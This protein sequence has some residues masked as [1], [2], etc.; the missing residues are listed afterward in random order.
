MNIILRQNIFTCHNIIAF[1]SILI[2]RR[3]KSTSKKKMTT[4]AKLGSL[5]KT[6]TTGKKRSA[7]LQNITGTISN[8]QKRSWG[9]SSNI[10]NLAAVNH[11]NDTDSIVDQDDDAVLAGVPNHSFL[12]P[13]ALQGE[14][15]DDDWDDDND[16]NNDK[17]DHF[18]EEYN[19]TV[20][21]RGKNSFAVV[22]QA[23]LSASLSRANVFASIAPDLSTL[24][25]NGLINCSCKMKHWECRDLRSMKL[26]LCKKVWCQ[27]RINHR[28]IAQLFQDIKKEHLLWANHWLKRQEGSL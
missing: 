19:A 16:D 27:C 5:A 10:T 17:G 23:R 12:S 26:Q 24:S 22:N 6:G 28:S 1:C 2:A 25:R 3:V 18:G 7:S 11:G 9:S 14:V 13:Q 20:Y 4:Q 8:K 15:L 21:D